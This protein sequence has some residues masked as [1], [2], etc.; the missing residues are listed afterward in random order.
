MSLNNAFNNKHLFD[1][2]FDPV[3]IKKESVLIFDFFKKICTI[4]LAYCY[5]DDDCGRAQFLISTFY[6]KHH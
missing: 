5:Y 1:S 2:L 6:K 4:I 3:I